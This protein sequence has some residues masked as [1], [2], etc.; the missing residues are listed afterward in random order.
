MTNLES[1]NPALTQTANPKTWQPGND[2]EPLTQELGNLATWQ[3]GNLA[4]TPTANTGTKRPNT[5]P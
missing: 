2:S 5:N 1:S 3:P 4:L